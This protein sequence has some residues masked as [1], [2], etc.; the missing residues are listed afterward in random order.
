VV[1][2]VPAECRDLGD[3]I[4]RVFNDAIRAGG[5]NEGSGAGAPTDTDG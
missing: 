2:T 1:R 3:D 4:K 5:D